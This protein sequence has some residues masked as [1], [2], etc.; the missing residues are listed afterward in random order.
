MIP[1]Y[2][3]DRNRLHEFIDN[4]TTALSLIKESH[5]NIL[6]SII[7][8][9]LSDKARAL[10]RNREF[11]TWKSSKDHLLDGYSDRRT[12]G[13]WQLELHSCKQGNN[14]SVM[15]FSNRIENCY[16]KLLSTMDLDM[17]AENRKIYTEILQQQA[18]NVFLMGLCQDIAVIVKSRYPKN[19]EDAVRLALNEEQE[20]KSKSE[21]AKI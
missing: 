11:E 7:K 6:F 1:K 12:Q 2:D 10:I 14:E 3:G 5:T 19:L 4:C 16:I 9:K 15:S 13:Q 18:L 21:I 17:S 8:T 20:T